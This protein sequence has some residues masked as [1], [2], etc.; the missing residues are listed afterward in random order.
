MEFTY[1]LA[2]MEDITG[3]AFRNIC[4]KYGADMTFTSLAKVDSLARKNASTWS[5]IELKD[6]TPAIIQLIGAKETSFTKFL[7]IFE[8]IGG[9]KGFNLN[10]GCPSPQVI[11]TGQGCAMIKRISKTK[12]LV[13]VFRDH[14]F[15]ISIKMRLGLNKFEKEKKAYLN[16]ITAIDADFFVVHARHGAQ[17]YN[18][19]ADFSVFKE[20]ADTGRKIIANGGVTTKE[21]VEALKGFGVQ[22]AMLG[23]AAVVDPGVFNRL[24]GIAAPSAE[25]II[26][27]YI[28]LSEQ[29]CEPHKYRLNVM[30]HS[31]GAYDSVNN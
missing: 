5:R 10:L 2:P 31:F 21:D 4:H 16:L 22:G 11:S 17:T 29:Y 19:A 13:K 28:K 6:K 3:N 25:I 30:K 14:G 27:E 15:P 23:R 9:F 1:M 7:D 8:P 20:C 12:N 24:K 18:D 26:Q